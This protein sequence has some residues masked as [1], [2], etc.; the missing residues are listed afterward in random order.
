[1][2][3]GP[4]AT[5]PAER[6]PFPTPPAPPVSVAPQVDAYD[7]QAYRCKPEDDFAKIS[8]Q[9]YQSDRYARALLMHNRNHPRA[10][11]GILHDPPNLAGAQIYIPPLRILEKNYGVL[12]PDFKPLPAVSAPPLT[13][14]AA[15]PPAGTAP[16]G[17]PGVAPA[18][19]A[20]GAPGAAPGAPA[21]GTS[22]ASPGGSSDKQYRVAGNGEWYRDIAARTLGNRERWGE[23]Y[24]LNGRRFPPENPVPPGIVLRLPADA[25]VDAQ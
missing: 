19:A 24:V 22:W 15:A 25:R 12:I 16:G 6:P 1:V 9:V 21:T 8:Q 2:P 14:G 13:P 3:T 17:A 7:E 5:A 23:I 4:V 18:G 11:E 20:G 10:A